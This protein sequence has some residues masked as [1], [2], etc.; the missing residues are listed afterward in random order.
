MTDPEDSKIDR[1][2]AAAR[3]AGHYDPG[4]EY[5]F[6][7]RV[8][9][10][11]RAEREAKIPFILWAWRLTPLFAS[12]VIILGIWISAFES[13]RITDLSAAAGIRNEEFMIAASL[14]GE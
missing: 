11:I 2:F 4:R 5:G 10:R 9:S 3:K 8:M 6:E 7:T 13:F 12:I 14:T 1:L